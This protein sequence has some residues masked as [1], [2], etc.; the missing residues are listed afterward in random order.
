MRNK[1]AEQKAID[2]QLKIVYQEYLEENEACCYCCGTHA[3]YLDFSHLVPR[4]FNR[5]LVTNPYNIVLKCR[6]HHKAWEAN[7]KTMPK[8]GELTERVRLLD[9]DYYNIRINK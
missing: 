7:D 8:Y 4:S 3:G 9:K 5:R 2:A 1:S 6:R